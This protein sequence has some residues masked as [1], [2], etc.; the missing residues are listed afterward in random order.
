MDTRSLAF[1]TI[2]LFPARSLTRTRRLLPTQAGQYVQKYW[3]VLYR[4]SCIHLYAQ[5]R[6]HRPRLTGSRAH[7]GYFIHNCEICFSLS[8]DSAGTLSKFI[9]NERRDDAGK[10]QLQVLSPYPL[11]VLEPFGRPFPQPP[12]RWP[13]RPASL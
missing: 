9:L 12:V 6:R 4:I 13:Q 7:V 2:L 11:I 5:K 8:S 10:L 3:P 1:M